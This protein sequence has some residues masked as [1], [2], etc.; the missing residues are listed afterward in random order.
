MCAP[1]H[2]QQIVVFDKREPPPLAYPGSVSLV[3]SHMQTIQLLPS[4]DLP[5]SQRTTLSSKEGTRIIPPAYAEVVTPG[6][7]TAALGLWL[8]QLGSASASSEH[9]TESLRPTSGPCPGRLVGLLSPE[10]VAGSLPQLSGLRQGPLPGQG[11]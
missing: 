11:T 5:G 2:P 3:C 7:R 10:H 4:Q 9:C 6:S 8:L 1:L